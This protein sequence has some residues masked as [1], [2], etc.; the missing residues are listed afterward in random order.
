LKKGG[1][2][3]EGSVFK[4]DGGKKE[5]GGEMEE[6]ALNPTVSKRRIPK[7]QKQEKRR[8]TGAGGNEKERAPGFSPAETC[9][10]PGAQK[11]KGPGKPFG[12]GKQ[13]TVRNPR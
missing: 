1:G 6:T 9:A 10:G 13:L 2:G 12:G 8:G 11:E 7:P 4:I 5:R 3:G